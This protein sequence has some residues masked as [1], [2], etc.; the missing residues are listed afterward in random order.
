MVKNGSD[1]RFIIMGVILA[2]LQ[3]GIITALILAHIAINN[4][5]LNEKTAAEWDA[6]TYA[7]FVELREEL[8]QRG[9]VLGENG[10]DYNELEI[11]GD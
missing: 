5:Q 6:R 7:E 2:V 11:N 1:T 3:I 4:L 10:S 9:I 8:R